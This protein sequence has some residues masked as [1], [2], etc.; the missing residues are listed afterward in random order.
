MG[1]YQF[2][3]QQKINASIDEAWDF[4]SS[5]GNL[6]EITPDSMGFE[7]I[8]KD[9]PDSMHPGM[10]IAYLVKPLLGIRTKWVTEITQVSEKKYFV[11]EQR[12]GPYA[13]WHHQHFIEQID[14]GVLMTDIVSYKPPLG[15]LGNIANRL[16]IRGKLQEIFN[17]RNAALER[18]YGKYRK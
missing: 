8:S 13:M 11:D 5:P 6:K 17:Y 4:I 14:D 18:K 2:K 1:F 12:V 7:I 10:I 15:I 16:F 3:K 9:L